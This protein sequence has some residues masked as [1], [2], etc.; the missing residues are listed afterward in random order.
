MLLRR[1]TA[2]FLPITGGY[3]RAL[4]TRRRKICAMRNEWAFAGRARK[5]RLRVDNFRRSPFDQRN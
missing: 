2:D 3:V 4:C 5:L 1:K